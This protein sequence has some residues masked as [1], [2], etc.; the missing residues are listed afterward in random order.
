MPQWLPSMIGPNV[1]AYAKFQSGHLLCQSYW[2]RLTVTDTQL[3]LAFMPELE[4]RVVDSRH[5]LHPIDD[6]APPSPSPPLTGTKQHA[7]RDVASRGPL[8]SVMSASLTHIRSGIC[9][10]LI[11]PGS[12]LLTFLSSNFD[13]QARKSSEI[14]PDA[15][16]TVFHDFANR[17]TFVSESVV[18][19]IVANAVHHAIRRRTGIRKMRTIDEYRSVLLLENPAGAMVDLWMLCIRRR[20][21]LTDGDGREMSERWHPIP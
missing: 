19:E 10:I 1:S 7:I 11:I 20:N 6:S 14:A 21:D 12:I 3:V 5:H 8:Q 17:F 4:R 16:L 15:L 2:Y 9:V 18:D 13:A